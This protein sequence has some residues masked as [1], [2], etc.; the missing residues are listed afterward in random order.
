MQFL[1]DWSFYSKMLA[2]RVDC[3][4]S[5]SLGDAPAEIS[6]NCIYSGH[7]LLLSQLLWRPR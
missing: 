1:M 5:L 6:G 3:Q 7:V 2:L 4:T